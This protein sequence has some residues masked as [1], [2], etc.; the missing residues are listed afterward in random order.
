MTNLRNQALRF[1][2]PLLLLTTLA[3]GH[4]MA[5][6]TVEVGTCLNGYVTF[7][8]IQNAINSSPAG[9]TIL[10]CPG[11]YQEQPIINKTLILKGVTAGGSSFAV[12]ASPSG[13]VVVNATD[14]DSGTPVAAQILVQNATGVD[15]SYLTV[16][17]DGN[18]LSGC[19]AP[20]LVGIFYQNASGTINTVAARNQILANPD[21]WGCQNGFGMY[22]QSNGGSSNLTIETS[23]IHNFQKNGITANDAGTYITLTSNKVE[24]Q[25]PWNGAAQNGIQIAFGAQGSATSNVA[26]DNI[27]I[28]GNY[29]GSGILVYASAGITVTKN[30]VGSSQLGISFDSD[31]T[32]GVADN[33]IITSNVLIGTQIYDAIDACSN[34]N[35]IESNRIFNSG[36]SAVHLDD[37]CNPPGSGNNNIATNNTIYESCA[38]ILLGSGTGNTVSSNKFENVAFDTLSGDYCTLPGHRKTAHQKLR[39]QPA[40]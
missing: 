23:S 32:Y 40:R 12:I 9:T 25:G 1:A 20:D 14:L 7:P 26:F 19:G 11:T 22:V 24:G 17:G 10:I 31:P 36:E 8:T 3:A 35:T 13:G 29:A 34:N 4:A 33:G 39:P 2:L 15:I 16:D 6:N 38:G 18:G 27:Y 30:D 37:E 5:A 28:P 21:D